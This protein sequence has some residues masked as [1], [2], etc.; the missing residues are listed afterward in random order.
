MTASALPDR[1]SPISSGGPMLPLRC[2]VST[3]QNSFATAS[4]RNAEA[5]STIDPRAPTRAPAVRNCTATVLS[6]SIPSTHTLTTG[7][8][9]GHDEGPA[10]RYGLGLAAG[11][12]VGGGLHVG[13]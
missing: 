2:P 3:G 1:P 4:T 11:L 10:R 12:R 6:S 13:A 5:R 7:T 9:C 8:S